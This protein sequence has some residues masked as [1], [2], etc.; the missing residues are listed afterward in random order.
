MLHSIIDNMELLIGISFISVTLQEYIFKKKIR[1][2][3]NIWIFS[4]YASMISILIM[5]KSY[6]HKGIAVDLRSIPIFLVSYMYGW[7]AGLISVILPGLF[8]YY[9]GGTTIWQEIIMSL[10]LPTLMGSFFHNPKEFKQPYSPFNIKKILVVY[11][12]NCVIRAVLMWFTV[13]MSYY[14][15]IELNVNMTFISLLSLL[16][17]ALL[18]N[19]TNRKMNLMIEMDKK[20][21]KIECLNSKLLNSN[22]TLATLIDVMPVG[23][24]VMD[25]KGNIILT[26]K[27]SEDILGGNANKLGGRVTSSDEKVYFLHSVDGSKIPLEELPYWQTIKNGKTMKDEE[28][29]VR[30]KD[31]TEKVI[32]IS[33]APVYDNNGNITNGVA[34][35]KD[36]THFKIIEDTLRDGRKISEAFLNGIT[37]ILMLIDRK[38]MI[39]EVNETCSKAFDLKM[40]EA[41]GLN[42]L[43]ILSPEIKEKI[44]NKLRSFIEG[45]KK[46]SFEEK[47]K[48]RYFN[49][50]LYPILDNNHYVEK[51]VVF[52][53][54]ITKLKEADEIRN[55][56]IKEL[57]DEQQKLEK[58]NYK[59]T[60]LSKQHMATL[61]ALY[62]KNEELKI[63]NKSKNNFIANVSH[64]LKTP[65]NITMTYLE[66]LLEEQEEGLSK[67]QK[68]M[69]EIAYS[70]ADRLQY[71]INDLLDI[72]LIEGQKTKLNL[73]SINLIVF[74]KTLIGERNLI[75]KDK[76]INIK[77]D[78][79]R[80]AIFV[81]TD[82][83]RLRQV[84]DNILDNAIKFSYEGDIEVS[85]EEKQS[86]IE[87]YIKD[88][89]IGIE[90]NK[91][92]KIF[93]PFYQI[94]DS[95]KKKYK[96]VG[97]GLYIAKN[98]INALGG[99]ISAQNNIEKGCCFKIT[100]PSD[101]SQNI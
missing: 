4:M 8:R 96:G 95:S 79:P 61:E 66:Y 54:D 74:L 18:T 76:N 98:I 71:L 55:Q 53:K 35:F 26:N 29:L 36:I 31:K 59:L 67:E 42:I 72:S 1:P 21:K 6:Y 75:I 69:L 19:N 101:C 37:E 40:N 65:L 5:F 85:L 93:K 73:K 23:I 28:I 7:K 82:A 60:M 78:V 11:S 100:I 62:K 87:V 97:L 43:D 12:I 99:D 41:R 91:L 56:F 51:F 86:N 2:R 81:V 70:N 17:M 83:L 68:Q 10:L 9:I 24:V 94:D 77:L 15:F 13:P 63:A 57:S 34:V 22:N 52:A 3:I 25:T 90:P 88:S 80:K 64:E 58:Q 49:I 44:K 92:D 30:R 39:L 84:I 27:T 48:E 45:R 46:V 50:V 47:L 16:C 89:G 38:G 33:S 14:E 20:Q 32:L